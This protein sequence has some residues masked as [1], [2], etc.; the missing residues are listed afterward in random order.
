[1]GITT[2]QHIVQDPRTQNI[3]LILTT[4]GFKQPKVVWAK[5]MEVLQ[6]LT[7]TPPWIKSEEDLQSLVRVLEKA[8]EEAELNKMKQKELAKSKKITNSDGT[9]E[10]AEPRKRKRRRVTSTKLTDSDVDNS[11]E[12]RQ[13][14]EPEQWPLPSSTT[15]RP[16]RSGDLWQN[17]LR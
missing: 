6:A 5:E 10:D 15:K 16:K 2:F 1:M 3:P 13:T 11:A 8:V 9:V 12:S 4:P 17:Y 14:N 7:N